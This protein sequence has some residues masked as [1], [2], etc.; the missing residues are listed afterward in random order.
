MIHE[1]IGTGATLDEARSKAIAE[2][3]APLD[4]DVV[5]EI[6]EQ[7][8]KKTLGLFGGSPAKVRAYYEKPGD[9]PAEPKT[10]ASAPQKDSTPPKK[11]E[12]KS[13]QPKTAPAKTEAKLI[14][15]PKSAPVPVTPVPSPVAPVGTV[16][17]S[18]NPPAN[19]L[20]K[21]LE[22]MG[23]TGVTIVT[24]ETDEEIFLEIECPEDYG[25]IIG[26]R[27]ETLD[28]LQYL[29]RLSVNRSAGEERRVTLNIGD[30]RLK[31]EETLTG[32]AKRQAARVIKYGRNAV[33][34]PMNPYERRIIHT[35][36]QG[37]QGVESHSIGEGE[38]RRVVITPVGGQRFDRSFD[39]G[40]DRDRDHFRGGQGGRGGFK[41]TRR[42]PYK[43]EPGEPRE[44]KADV[45]GSFRYGKIEPKNK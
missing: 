17:S 16:V 39:K 38:G 14:P 31:R 3:N 15:E 24:R 9:N 29:V 30:Y 44:P 33:L 42:E 10:A 28:A 6:L 45:Q 8:T 22:G 21:I 35:T 25:S 1:A 4:A 19:Y 40:R 23:L 13:T 36:V 20:K 5:V 2:L 27:G 37:L 11:P 18:D 26:R 12:Q 32:L 7:A 41:D 43:P 34:D